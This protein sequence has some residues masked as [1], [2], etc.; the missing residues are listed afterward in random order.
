[1][2][3]R[4]RPCTPP[5]H[6]QALQIK[7]PPPTAW[8]QGVGRAGKSPP[9][10]GKILSIQ[11]SE[12]E[13][14]PAV[15]A[16]TATPF[17]A[18]ACASAPLAVGGRD[19]ERDVTNIVIDT[20]GVLFHEGQSFGVI[21]PGTKL[22]SKGK[23][24]PE[25]NRLYSI[26]SSRYGDKHDGSTCTLCVVRVIWRGERAG[27]V[28][29]GQRG[30]SRAASAGPGSVTEV[31]C[32]VCASAPAAACRREWPGAAWPVLQ[33]PGRPQSG[34]RAAN[35]RARGHRHG[36]AQAP[37]RCGG[38]LRWLPARQPPHQQPPPRRPA[39]ARP[40]LLPDDHMQRPIVCVATG[41][42]IAP[43]RSFW[44]RLFFDGVP[45]HPAGYQ[46]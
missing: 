14:A 18:P 20:G 26:A 4:R 21:P 33:L 5:L 19:A 2:P 45:G 34:R 15:A 38:P 16:A 10:Q 32:R 29:G 9:F 27:P 25:T 40:Q 39:R 37:G 46:V 17:N 3:R 44:R 24:V 35:D 23:E 36:E 43:F 41:T 7:P 22:N 6:G 31:K 30:R 11:R 1:M 42:G 8:L 28:G 12:L 13:A